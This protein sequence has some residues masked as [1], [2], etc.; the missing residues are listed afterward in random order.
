MAGNLLPDTH[1][2]ISESAC[3]RRVGGALPW[4]QPKRFGGNRRAIWMPV[5]RTWR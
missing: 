5:P 2:V 3:P 1:P 4:A